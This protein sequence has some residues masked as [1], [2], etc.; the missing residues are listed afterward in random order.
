TTMLVVGEEGWPLEEDGQPSVKLQQ[1]TEW[2]QQGLDIK[3][4][5]ESE[6]LHLLGLEERRRDVHRL[7][8]PAM[9]SQSLDVSV[10]LIRHWERIRLIKPVKKVFRLPYFDFQEVACV[11]RLSELLQAGVRRS[12]LEASLSKLQAMLPGTERSLAQLTLLARD[13]HVVLRDAAG[14]L[15]PTTRQRLFDFDLSGLDGTNKTDRTDES[16]QSHLSDSSQTL[17]ASDDPTT[18]PAREN[19]SATDW[20]EQGSQL[21]EDNRV[22]DAI[23]AFRIALLDQPANPETHFHLA[24]ALYRASNLSAAF[25]RFHVAVELDQQYLEA[26]TQ[27]G[28]VAAELGQ[29]QSALDAFDIALHSHADYPDAHF[30]KAE[31]L[32]RLNRDDEARPHWQ[33]YLEHDQRGPWADVA[34]QRLSNL[35]SDTP[36]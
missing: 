11:R 7:L 25:E 17:A 33:A 20:L 23:E 18:P 5:H 3:V 12:E 4:L 31:L 34:K 32:H 19:W 16:N 6:W 2:R 28:C 26:W 8:T 1:V 35:T 22:T 14:L 9:L 15:E 29:T 10:G 27:L 30:H 21:L 24:E 36:K 13:H